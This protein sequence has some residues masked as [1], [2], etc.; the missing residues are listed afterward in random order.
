M[1]CYNIFEELRME[2][3]FDK[4]NK[5]ID[6][7]KGDILYEQGQ[8]CDTMF[9]LYTGKMGLYYNYGKEN[10]ICLAT[11]CEKGS[12]LG[13]M[14][15]LEGEPRNG[16]AVALEDTKVL[17]IRKDNL[18]AFLFAHPNGGVK[19][20]QDLANR[21][22]SVSM[23]LDESRKLLRELVDSNTVK[24]S[25]ISDRFKRI[26][27]ILLDVPSDVPVDL[28]MSCYTRNNTNLM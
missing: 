11:I 22:K 12:S 6:L 10:E 2:R 3:F 8:E 4:N 19:M 14:G 26:A 24:K 20:I 9:L 5:L 1:L 21:F 28:Y 27:D 16:T 25:K 7:S 13:E 23:Q 18:E 17:E 15:L